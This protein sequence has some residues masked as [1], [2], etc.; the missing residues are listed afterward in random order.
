M[1]LLCIGIIG[2]YLA[3]IYL[4][5]KRRPHFLIEKIAPNSLQPKKSLQPDSHNAG[6]IDLPIRGQCADQELLGQPQEEAPS[7]APLRNCEQAR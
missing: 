1:Q 2:E 4:E 6:R 7:P 5:T 3:K